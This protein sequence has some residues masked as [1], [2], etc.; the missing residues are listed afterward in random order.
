[1]SGN[2]H[3]LVT[4]WIGGRPVP[5][6]SGRTAPVYDPARGEQVAEVALA[7]AAE[8]DA[9][10]KQAAD[11]AGEWGETSL[12]R[13]AAVMFRLRELLD[14]RRDDLAAAITREHGKVRSDALG[15]VARGLECVEF[16][17]GIPHLLKGT[18]SA[19]AS[20]G[21]D[22]HT[23]LQPLGVV[24]GITPFNFP[25]MVP[26][27]MLANAVACGNAFVLKPSEK[28]PSPSLLLAELAAEAGFP[29]GVVT[30][31]QGD[32]E[33]VDAILAAPDVAAVSF[34]G[35]TPIARH[36][37]E[38][39][40]RAGKRVQALGGAK[41]H[42]VV[43]PDADVA[44]AADAAVS[45]AYG[46]A[47][48]RCMA[49]S[50]VVAVGGVADELVGAI[51]D[52]IPGVVIGPGD[53]EASMMG[54]LVTREHRDR[55]RSYVDGAAGEG[56]RV[57]VDGPAP[58]APGFWAGCALVD[59]VEPGMRLYDDEIFGPVLS[60][61][62]VPTYDEA[63]TLVNANPYGNGVALFTRD[64]GAAR[65]FQRQVDVGMVGINVP[66]PVPVAWHSFGGWKASLFGDSAMYGPEGV[67]FYTRPKVV[68]TRWPDPASSAIDLGFPTTS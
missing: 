7:S 33:A 25:V 46:S 66:I 60:V 65:L 29:D 37:Y 68:T 40:T 58:D 45:A 53:D 9:A 36:V 32:A 42:M 47:G 17:C 16:A 18:L 39:G 1:M 2:A 62:R 24:A 21:V 52:R 13:R 61:V 59:G 55:V 4:H 11:A 38:A 6:A 3:S 54:P 57:V 48:E 43:L 63:V 35:S 50:V 51:A 64:G 31:V 22:V 14:G 23:L 67:R 41:N 30:V 10:V 12:S 26:L 28:D 49:I 27:W 56:A 20:G 19:E 15:E 5:G 34:V 8:V 44:A